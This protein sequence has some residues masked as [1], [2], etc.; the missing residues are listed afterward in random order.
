MPINAFQAAPKFLKDTN[1]ALT[2]G[3]LPLELIVNSHSTPLQ[4]WS[5]YPAAR[6]HLPKFAAQEISLSQYM[7]LI[8]WG[9]KTCK[10]I[11]GVTQPPQFL[12]RQTKHPKMSTIKV[13]L[14]A[15]NTSKNKLEIWRP[16]WV[17]PFRDKTATNWISQCSS[18]QPLSNNRPSN[19]SSPQ[20]P[21]ALTS[22]WWITVTLQLLCNTPTTVTPKMR[23][24]WA[25]HLPLP[26][27]SAPLA[28]LSWPPSKA[29]R[30]NCWNLR[31]G[32]MA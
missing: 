19:T 21:P 4:W 14:A 24:Y 22:K 31:R 8:T 29:N 26:V 5:L 7:K 1:F 10:M 13:T 3:L 6:G 20:S 16:P 17:P 2:A 28:S 15:K 32:Q 18:T 23:M 30:S 9:T 11:I 25:Y 12:I 27:P